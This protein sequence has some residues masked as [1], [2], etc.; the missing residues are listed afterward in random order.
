[1]IRNFYPVPC[2]RQRTYLYLK[3]LYSY[4]NIGKKQIQI[5]FSFSVF[6]PSKNENFQVQLGSKLPTLET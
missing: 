1:M 4:S 3:Y 6:L 5:P 2:L